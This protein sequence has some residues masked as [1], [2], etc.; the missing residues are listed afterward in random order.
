MQPK[1]EAACTFAEHTGA[2]A[3]IGA[4]SAIPELVVGTAGTVVSVTFDPA[5]VH[6]HS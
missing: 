3:V 1:V 4:L 5:I 6:E 2:R